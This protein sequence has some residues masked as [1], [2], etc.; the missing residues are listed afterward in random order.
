MLHSTEPAVGGKRQQQALAFGT[1]H[2]RYDANKARSQCPS[3]TAKPWCCSTIT[4]RVLYASSCSSKLAF[5]CYTLSSPSPASSHT[6]AF[7]NT[8]HPLNNISTTT[9]SIHTNTPIKR[10]LNGTYPFLLVCSVLL[11]LHNTARA[12]RSRHSIPHV[13]LSGASACVRVNCIYHICMHVLST[14]SQSA[15]RTQ[16]LP[17]R[18][19]VD[20]T[21]AQ[22]VQ[23]V[24]TVHTTKLYT[25]RAALQ[26]GQQA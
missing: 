10:L 1:R 18:A 14:L 6:R 26:H 7:I 16:G 17:K 9:S 24:C 2:Q 21:S 15:Y 3:Y 11:E 12:Q 25:L 22:R 20:T 4:S 5:C 19:H 8:T 23:F 13:L